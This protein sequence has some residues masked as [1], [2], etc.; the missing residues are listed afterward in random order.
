MKKFLAALLV[1][2][3]CL[4]LCATASAATEFSTTQSFLTMMDDAEMKYTNNGLDS[5]GDEHVSMSYRDDYSSYTIHYF[6]EDNLEH[7]SIFVWNI[8]E[9][10]AK[11]AL[12][13]MQVCNE[14]N[15]RYN[16]TCWYVDE[17]DNTVTCSM[18]LIYRDDNVG[19]VVTE[20]TVY[21]M[22]IIE[23]GYPSLAVYAK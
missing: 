5:D 12:H 22:E 13:V 19:L 6:F 11:D 15:A 14:L 4:S 8:I 18:N 7:T 20:A 3:L 1:S 9:F 17:T 23:H 10:D 2:M 16:Y 21:L